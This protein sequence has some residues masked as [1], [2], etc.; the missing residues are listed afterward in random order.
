M[1][2]LDSNQYG[3]NKPIPSAIG[4]GLLTCLF[5][6]IT[7][8]AAQAANDTVNLFKMPKG[9]TPMFGFVMGDDIDTGTE[10]YDFDVGVAG[11]TDKFGNFGVVT[12]DAVAGIKPEV[13]IWMPLA[14]ELCTEAPAEV[15]VETDVI[16][17]VNAAAQAGGTG[18]IN[19]YLMGT[20]KDPRV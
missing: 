6:T 10:A 9:F 4:G 16:L 15:L 20:Y 19:V 7:L 17:T 3:A 5:G 12:G 13:C 18:T 1:A 14:G 8:A 11:N 2:S